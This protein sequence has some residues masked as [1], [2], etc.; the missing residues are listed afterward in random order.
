MPKNKTPDY[1]LRAND[2]YRDRL[3]SRGLKTYN[4]IGPIRDEEKVHKFF[5]KLRAAYEKENK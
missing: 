3:S 5:A 2:D 4:G 1:R